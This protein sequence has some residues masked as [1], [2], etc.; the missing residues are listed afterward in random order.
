MSLFYLK[1]LQTYKI[2]SYSDLDKVIK[3]SNHI[4]QIFG[5][6]LCQEKILLR[7]QVL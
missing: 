3:N 6:V 7:Y 2:Y 4:K 1:L 5:G